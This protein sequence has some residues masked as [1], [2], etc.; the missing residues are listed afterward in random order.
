M[1]CRLW[2]GFQNKAVA[3]TISLR[4]I[5]KTEESAAEWIDCKDLGHYCFDCQGLLLCQFVFRCQKSSIVE[6]M[7][8]ILQ[9]LH[10]HFAFHP[11][12]SHEKQTSLVPQP[13]GSPELSPTSF[14][15][16]SERMFT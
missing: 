14:F 7:V 11:K 16:F 5:S 8:E 12:V 6:E 13:H 1:K 15:L 2:V 3:F 9:H 10:A 4:I